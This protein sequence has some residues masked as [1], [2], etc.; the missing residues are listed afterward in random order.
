LENDPKSVRAW[1]GKGA[2]AGWSSTLADFRFQEMIVALENAAKYADVKT[3]PQV[4]KEAAHTI[5]QVAIACYQ[6]S[7]KHVIEY[8]ALDNTWAEYIPRCEMI[9]SALQVAH[10]YDP[11][12]QT[13][14]ENVIHLCRDN[15]EGVAY[16]D[17][18]DNNIRKTV[19][20]SDNYE[21]QLRSL[22]GSFASKLKALNPAY[23]PPEAKRP[24]SGCFVVT[25]TFDDENHPHVRLLRAFRDEI[26]Q[27][28]TVGAAICRAYYRHGP[29]LARIVGSSALLRVVSHRA[30]VA[31]AVLLARHLL[32][33]KKSGRQRRVRPNPSLKRSANGRP[34]GPGWRYAVHFRQP[35]PGVLPSSPA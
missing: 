23:E 28:S 8:I 11:E 25:A 19:H 2:S 4:L 1:I 30:V 13:I 35:G 26:L 10:E 33:S 16:N 17:P 18:Y 24:S 21:S 29:K 31:P 22:M 27:R 14:I 6:I 20:L 3:K 34:P 5:N 12:N 15:I 9:T 7:R 32:V